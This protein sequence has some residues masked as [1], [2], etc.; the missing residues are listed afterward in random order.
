MRCAQPKTGPAF[1]VMNSNKNS[2]PERIED[3]GYPL[4]TINSVNSGRLQD[5]G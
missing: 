1:K 2:Y 3:R 5:P 4:S